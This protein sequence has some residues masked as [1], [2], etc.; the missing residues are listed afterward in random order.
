MYF[1]LMAG[2]IGSRFWPRS[3]SSQPKQLLQILGT[4][5]MMQMTYDRIRNLAEPEKILIVTNQDLKEAIAEQIPDIPRENIIGEPFGRNTAPCVGLACA[6]MK[7]REPADSNEVM[8]V[9]PADHLIQDEQKY[10]D[11]LKTAVNYA[12]HNDYLLT[13]GIVP[14]Y[15]E[16]GYGYIQRNEAV[17]SSNQKTIYKVKTFAEKPNRDTAERFLKSGDFF[18]NSGM[19]VWNYNTIMKEFEEYI[20]ELAE[21]IH[22]IAED[23]GTD[24]QDEAV[25]DLYSKIKSISLDYGILEV[26]KRVGVIEGDF[27]WNDVGSWEAVYN[28]S[29]KDDQ[30]NVVNTDK[31][32]MLNAGDNYLYS[33]ENK[34][35]VAMDVEGLVLV[36]TDDA[37]LICKKE[38]SQNVKNVVDLL[39]QKNWD[40]YL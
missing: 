21:G 26:S 17:L 14:A 29:E 8:V 32:I 24:N 12:A 28:I 5:S 16:T 37:I 3:R 20:P 18:W 25:L 33:S 11:V 40:T 38:K 27:R 9:L 39:R 6:F 31:K 35:I 15:P 13:I 22:Q 1:V 34:I 10:L 2:G 30:A 7:N 19:F 4:R 36:E 23:V